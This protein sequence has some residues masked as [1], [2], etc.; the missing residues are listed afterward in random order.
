[1]FLQKKKENFLWTG[2]PPQQWRPP[3]ATSK[4]PIWLSTSFSL[5]KW[6]VGDLM[7]Y[8]RVWIGRM[9]GVFFSL[10]STDFIAFVVA[11]FKKMADQ[12]NLSKFI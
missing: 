6:V 11:F 5:E 7:I 9:D 4:L 1:M 12:T 8:T 10:P 3:A 2:S